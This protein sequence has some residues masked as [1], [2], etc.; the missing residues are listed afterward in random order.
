MDSK[1]TGK[2]RVNWFKPFQAGTICN[3][4]T[5]RGECTQEDYRKCPCGGLTRIP[6]FKDRPM[7]PQK[8]GP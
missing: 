6:I 4:V 7:Y 2:C 8:E 3:W 5:E 1:I